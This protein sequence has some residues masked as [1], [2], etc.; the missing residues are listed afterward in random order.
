[1]TV[2][3]HTFSITCTVTK[4]IFAISLDKQNFLIL[5]VSW[6]KKILVQLSKIFDFDCTVHTFF[7]VIDC[8]QNYF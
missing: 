6:K 8:E 7:A 4:E 3:Q 5:T 2:P 1:M